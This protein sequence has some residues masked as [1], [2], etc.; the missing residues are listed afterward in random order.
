MIKITTIMDNLSSAHKALHS[1]HGLC[2]CIETEGRRILFDFGAGIHALENARK[3]NIRPEEMDYAV[4][5]HGH[6]DHAGG[7]PFFAESGLTC[8]F[9]A[10]PGF[11]T[12]KYALEGIRATYLGT[13]FGPHYLEEKGISCLEA[14]PVLQLT[15]NCWALG[16]FE[17]KWA[18]ETIPKRFVLRTGDRFSPDLFED[19]ICLAVEEEGSLI[20]ILGCSHPGILNILEH[21][22]NYFKKPI[23]AVVGGTHLVE[24]GRERIEKTISVM[25]GM[26]ISLI[27]FNHCSG[28]LLIEM[29]KEETELNTVYLGAGDCLFL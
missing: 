2:F 27:G 10:G 19:E 8:P 12:E 4:G 11:F 3:L 21:V 5:S 28:P 6:Y 7:Y 23:Q 15:K 14:A 18:F 22:Q 20:V 1:E 29:M 26:G 9:V 17:R 13:G 24:A 16:G 25:K